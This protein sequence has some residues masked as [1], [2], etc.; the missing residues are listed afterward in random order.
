MPAW[1]F[2][3]AAL[4]ALVCGVGW[5]RSARRLATARALID[6]RSSD[7]RREKELLDELHRNARR[8]A[9]AEQAAGFGIYDIDLASNRVTF[10]RGW[11]ALNGVTVQADSLPLSAI[12]NL[13]HPDDLTFV[14]K[15]TR[16]AL[17]A[18]GSQIMEFRIIKAD[19]SIRWHRACAMA[20][21]GSG[22]EMRVVGAVLDIT[23]EREMLSSLDD[24]R[25]RAEA[26]AQAKSDFLA[27]MSHE[28]RTPM[29]GVIG[30]TGLLLDTDLTP[31]QRDYAETVRHSGQALLTIINDIL[32]FSKIEAGKLDIDPVS[33][34]LRQLLE[35]VADMIAPKAAERGI[36]LL[37]RY[38]PNMPTCFIGDADRIRQVVANLASNAVKFTHVGH[39]LISAE[40]TTGGGDDG[41]RIAVADTG[42]GIAADKIEMLFEKFTQADTSTTRRYG[43]TGLGLAIS[44]R[45]LTLMG[46]AM[47]VES[48]KGAGSTFSFVLPLPVDTA[49][50]HRNRA[51]ALTAV[52][53]LH[54][55][56]V[57]DTEVSRRVL[58]EQ[59][60]ACGI[61]GS[62]ASA[63]DALMALRA[64][65]AADD[66]FDVVI[67]RAHM[68]GI[69]GRRLAEAIKSEGPLEDTVFVMLTPVNDGAKRAGGCVDMCLTTPVRQGRLLQ[70]LMAA[71][72][73]KY[74]RVVPIAATAAVAEAAVAAEAT[75]G[76]P[77]EFSGSGARVL[78]VEDN[79]VNQKVAVMLLAKFGVR[80]DVA[81]HGREAVD[82]MRLL[83]YDLILMDCQM[84]VMNGFEATTEI[85]GMD[86]AA[87][88]V[89]IL[90]LTADVITASRERCLGAG[91]N[92]FI[93]KPIEPEALVRALR[94]W[95]PQARSQQ[96]SVTP[97]S[98]AA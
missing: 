79:A 7:G 54:V 75:E 68:R 92:D 71:Q 22:T 61:R 11:A 5:I 52:A 30:M 82:M 10:S 17:T 51:A 15:I 56:V 59:I 70:A 93:A 65:R 50:S 91:M 81:G 88:R 96:D 39:V 49:M 89:P 28:I 47:H 36:D 23:Q 37:V 26:L 62:I 66:P 12:V 16:V 69:E 77:G 35:E 76:R 25:E 78:V 2:G 74:G 95:L 55:L 48:R 97:Q 64:A 24:A 29:N 31:E 4:A 8:M 53:G 57:D 13:I 1:L 94:T 67:A 72:E 46:G 43:G 33:F 21:R 6:T 80:A 98:S 32:D 3:G 85:R 42:I 14:Q 40:S 38:P 84:P 87:G 34:D 90:A 20:E 9:L 63:G 86:G 60:A 45:L 27:N 83:P 19:G 41:M 44:R 58:C 18:P 73:R